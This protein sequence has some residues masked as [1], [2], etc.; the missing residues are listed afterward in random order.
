MPLSH[1]DRPQAAKI[2]LRAP[3]AEEPKVQPEEAETSETAIVEEPEL[4]IFEENAPEEELP[5]QDIAQ[6]EQLPREAERENRKSRQVAESSSSVKRKQ[7]KARQEKQRQEEQLRRETEVRKARA[8]EKQRPG[9]DSSG[10]RRKKENRKNSTAE[11]HLQREAEKKA[12]KAAHQASRELVYVGC[13]NAP[14]SLNMAVDA[15]HQAYEKRHGEL[16]Q[17]AK[18]SSVKLNNRETGPLP[19]PIWKERI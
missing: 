10:V 17:V 5:E 7:E 13:S 16:T 19:S 12:Q 9:G 18:I 8:R 3:E 11:E 1:M 2:I 14:D 15:L 6:E 4:G